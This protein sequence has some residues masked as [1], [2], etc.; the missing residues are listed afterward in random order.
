MAD[1][2]A[3]ATRVASINHGII[4]G[5]DQI[6]I[7]YFAGNKDVY[8]PKFATDS[9]GNAVGIADPVGEGVISFAG[10][11]YTFAGLPA[12]SENNLGMSAR[13]TDIGPVGGSI[14][15]STGTYWKPLNGS[16]VLAQANGSVAA[17]IQTLSAAGKFTL[18]ADQMIT[19]GSLVLPTGLLRVGFTVTTYAKFKHRG[20]GGAWSISARLGTLNTSSD[21][22][23]TFQNGAATN[24]NDVW[25]VKDG[26]I[27]S[28]TSFTAD[29]FAVPNSFTTGAFTDKNSNFNTASVMY[30]GLYL[31]AVNAADFVDFIEYRVELKG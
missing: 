23:L 14:F 3:G 15:I 10:P 6:P 28:S 18:P 22:A 26:H 25:V 13:V 4:L 12:A 21:N 19:G 8:L 20:T 31:S 16:C 11:A 29:G 9:S 24:D 17:P 27:V 2:P 5:S 30:L 1:L 7:G